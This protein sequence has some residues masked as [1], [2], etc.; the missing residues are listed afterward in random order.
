MTPEGFEIDLFD[1]ACNG[2]D[3]SWFEETGMCGHCGAVPDKCDCTDDDPCGCDHL[4][5]VGRNL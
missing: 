1:L 3:A 5:P 2:T 4:H